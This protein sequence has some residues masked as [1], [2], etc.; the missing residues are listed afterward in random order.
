[1]NFKSK[2]QERTVTHSRKVNGKLKLY[3]YKRRYVILPIACEVK[4]G[5]LIEINLKVLS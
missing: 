1:M 2:V 5:D 3:T 4:K